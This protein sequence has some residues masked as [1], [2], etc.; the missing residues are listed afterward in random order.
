M[1]KRLSRNVAILSVTTFAVM[2][3]AMDGQAA[4]QVVMKNGTIFEGEIVENNARSP[5][6]ILNNGTKNLPIMRYQIKKVHRDDAA[7]AEYKR[8]MALIKAGHAAAHFRLYTWAKQKRLYSLAEEQLQATIVADTN[9]AEARKALGHVKHEGTWLTEE[10][11][12]RYSAAK[13][14]LTV[15]PIQENSKSREERLARQKK[16]VE[17]TRVLARTGS[18]PEQKQEVVAEILKDRKQIGGILVGCLD[19]RRIQDEEVRLGALKGIEVAKPVGSVVSSSLAWSSVYDPEPEVRNAAVS[20]IKTRKDDG[21]IGGMIRHLIGAFD[22]AGNVRNAPVRDAAVK[23][24]RSIGDTRVYEALLYYVVMEMRP[25]VTELK[26][27]NTRQIDS[28]TINQGANVSLAIPLS[29]PIQFPEL[30]IQRVRT[31]VC[32]PASALRAVSGQN[33]QTVGEWQKWIRR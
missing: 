5:E 3:Y 10:E 13:Q 1:C 14:T 31:S 29:F 22:N 24:L 8:Q 6:I 19:C 2:L 28:F 27:F 16:V 9:H 32:A 4:D 20:L 17:M 26:A 7:R 23:G 11:A 33:F 12:E 25:T 15:T 18:T 30:G 21:A